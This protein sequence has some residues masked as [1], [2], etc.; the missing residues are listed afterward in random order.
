MTVLSD[1]REALSAEAGGGEPSTQLKLSEAA[2]KQE[3]TRRRAA[4]Q[5]MVCAAAHVLSRVQEL[6]RSEAEAALGQHKGASEA[7]A[8]QWQQVLCCAARVLSRVPG[9]GA[10][11]WAEQQAA[12]GHHGLRAAQ[13]PGPRPDRAAAHPRAAQPAAA[14]GSAGAAAQPAGTAGVQRGERGAGDAGREE[15][16]Q[17]AVSQRCCVR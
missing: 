5:H 6:M 4:E 17:G 10:S 7:S 3:R 8:A 15:R 9:T 1:E 16:L 14:Q 2:L 12:R 13:G 11:L